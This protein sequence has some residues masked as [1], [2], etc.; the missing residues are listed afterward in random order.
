LKE[1]IESSKVGVGENNNT[2]RQTMA[3][4]NN[5]E[6]FKRAL[7][8]FITDEDPLFSML[9]WITDK[10]MQLE[11]EQKAGAAKGSHSS[12]R[13][14]H[15][16]GTR[17]RRF[18]TRLGTMY[19]LV[20]KLRKGGYIPFFVTER[21]RSEAALLEVVQEAYINGVSTRKIETL[22]KKLGVETLSASQVSEINK[23]L[24]EQVAAFRSRTLAEEYPI[25]WVD[26]LYEKIRDNGRVISEAVFVI[27]GINSEGRREIL[28]V[29]PMYDESEGS[30]S[31]VFEALKARGLK[32]VWL[33]VSDAHLG[34]QSAVGKHFLGASWQRCTVHFM[35]TV[36]GR[37]Q[38]KDKREFAAKLKQIWIQPDRK[39]AIRTAKIFIA[40]YRGKYPEAIKVLQDG[41]E[42]S[43]QFYA[44][45]DFDSRRISSTNGLERINKEVRRRSRVVGVFP[46]EGS[47]VRLLTCFLLEY[48]EDWM[49]E[50][51]Y[52]KKEVIEATRSKLVE[53]A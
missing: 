8:E 52:I 9:Q 7:L 13:V 10:L 16:S 50:R 25:I 45:P 3:K 29:E 5:S 23:G 6:Y 26:A 1:A 28:A 46:S 30:W 14:T 41:L 36:M 44:F 33:V 15:F 20:P 18:D 21:K 51:S 40:E 43:L 11:A 49:T 27:Y 22:A 39:S 38:K 32:K 4:L 48:S 37:V 34:I 17:V 19:M 47:Y 24:D 31:V 42:D 53:A 12:E 2:R 35:R